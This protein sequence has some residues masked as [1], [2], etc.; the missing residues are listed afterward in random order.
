M[1]MGSAMLTRTLALALSALWA[2]TALG[3]D[4]PAPAND[5]ARQADK[6]FLLGKE[7]LKAGNVREAYAE[8]KA[9]WDLKRSYDAATVASLLESSNS[10]A[11]TY[12]RRLLGQMRQVDTE[13]ELERYERALTRDG[14]LSA[15]G[16]TRRIRLVASSEWVLG[17]RITSEEREALRD[18]SLACGHRWASPADA[19]AY[20]IGKAAE[21]IRNRSPKLA[22]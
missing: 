13:E 3:S 18:E 22:C 2:T 16:G 21:A 1:L 5:A 11:L 20:A 9:A 4:T 6:H 17:A 10:I 8:Y 15:N 7:Q 14:M 12:L 19:L